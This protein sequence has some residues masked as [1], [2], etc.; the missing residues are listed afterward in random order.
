MNNHAFVFPGQGSQSV[1]MLS[2]MSAVVKET[3]D[4]A[5]SVLGYDLWDLVQND[6]SDQLNQTEFTQPALLTASIAIWRYAIE[7]GMSCPSAVAGHSLG[8]YS[9]LVAAEV[10][11]FQDAVLLVQ[12]RGQF[13]QSA[14]PL[15][16]G[17]MAAV[18]GLADELVIEICSRCSDKE[19]GSLVQAAN[20]NSPGQVVIAGH[21]DALDRASVALKESGAKKVMPLSVSAPFHS[22][23]MRPAAEKMAKILQK[24][25]FRSPKIKILQNVSAELV[26]NPDEIRSNMVEQMYSAVKWT[27]TIESFVETGIVTVV[28][29]GPGKV[30]SMLNR[31]IDK[32][33]TSFQ[34]NSIESVAETIAG[35]NE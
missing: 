32:S 2:D 15:G 30:L 22:E 9:A 10:L 13:M 23:A 17:G 28:E 4:Q 34:L 21:C 33:I 3:F 8:E 26:S 29:C 5:S 35:V 16:Q 25:E 11:E 20:F 24:T 12:Q 19:A 27:A 18:L 1:G 6:A 7:Q 31:R 14:V